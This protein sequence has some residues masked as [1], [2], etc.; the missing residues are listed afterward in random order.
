MYVTM[1]SL[2]EAEMIIG[3][4]SSK[5]FAVVSNISKWRRKAI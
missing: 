2:A 5:M 3:D 4:L 1:F